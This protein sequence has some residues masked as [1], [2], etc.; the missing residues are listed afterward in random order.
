MIC[1]NGNIYI[2]FITTE[3]L[4]NFGSIIRAEAMAYTKWFGEK[5]CQ[6]LY[7]RLSWYNKY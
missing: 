3:K 4:T 2:N 7:I 5:L 6:I 1:T